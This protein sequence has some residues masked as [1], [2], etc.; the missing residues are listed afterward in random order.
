MVDATVDIHRT[1]RLPELP[2]HKAPDSGLATPAFG[3]WIAFRG[4]H[5]QDALHIVKKES[6]RYTYGNGHTDTHAK[7]WNTNYSPKL[8]HIRLDTT[9]HSHLQHLPPIPLVT[10]PTHWVPKDT[11]YTDRDKQ[12]HYP[13]PI[14]QLVN[15][16]G[17]TPNTKFLQRLEDSVR[18]PL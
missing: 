12:Y 13:T 10:R 17:H 3:L 4:M 2:L 8:D 6:H 7:Y 16:L 9:H 18:T 15:T 11:R 1:K 14:L 5:P